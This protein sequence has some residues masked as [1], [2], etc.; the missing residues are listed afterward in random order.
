M[1]VI[2][3]LAQ[4][5]DN[6]QDDDA[7]YWSDSE[8][9]HLYNECKRFLAAERQEVQTSKVVPLVDNVN[10]YTVDGVL[11]YISALDSEGKER[12][13]YPDDGTGDDDA[14]GIIIHNYNL[15]YVNTPATGTSIILKTIAFPSNDNL[16]STIRMG[17]ENAFKYY[18]LSKAYEKESEM[19]NFQKA[20]YFIG[21]FNS[22][23]GTIKKAAKMN[24]RDTI[25]TTKG[26]Y[27]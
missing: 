17:D 7:N 19:E 13:L 12:E 6:L 23:L 24:Y 15:I 10:S 14:T 22:V 2:E 26:Y 1:K 27:Y 4:V 16:Q 21:M 20:Q 11:R 25:Q 18:V 9:L 5:R 8:L 3:L